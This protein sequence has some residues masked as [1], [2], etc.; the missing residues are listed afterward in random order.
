M[1]KTQCVSNREETKIRR[2]L[3]KHNLDKRPEPNELENQGILLQET[4]LK[5]DNADV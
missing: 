2:D 4:G 3:L 5:P 1:G